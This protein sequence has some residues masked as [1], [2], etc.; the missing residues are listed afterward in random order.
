[1]A[2][3]SAKEYQRFEDIKHSTDGGVEFRYVYELVP[4]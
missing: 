1:M 3:L 2:S 4:V